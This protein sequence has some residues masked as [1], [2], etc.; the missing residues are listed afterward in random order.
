[1]D[2]GIQILRKPYSQEEL[3]SLTKTDIKNGCLDFR[4]Q[5][6][7]HFRVLCIDGEQT[8]IIFPV[9]DGLPVLPIKLYGELWHSGWDIPTRYA[10]DVN[11]KCWK[12]GAHGGFVTPCTVD[13]L[14]GEAE[15][16]QA[17]NTI[18]R[19]LGLPET[20]RCSCCSGKGWV[21]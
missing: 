12:D 14:L 8:D 20:K 1:M 11:N 5:R 19:V 2:R 9:E 4:L 16:E 7:K 18:R 10:I 21:S 13:E 17:K 3:D 15:D 6:N